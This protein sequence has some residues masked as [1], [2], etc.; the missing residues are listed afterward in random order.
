MSNPLRF[1]NAS[2]SLRSGRWNLKRKSSRR[3]A[4]GRRETP[5]RVFERVRAAST[6]W[7]TQ[8]EMQNQHGKARNPGHHVG[9][10]SSRP[11]TGSSPCSFARNHALG[12]LC[13]P[14]RFSA[15]SCAS[16]SNDRR[17]AKK[18]KE[19]GR[20]KPP[21]KPP[22]ESACA[23]SLSPVRASRRCRRLAKMLNRLMYTAVVAIT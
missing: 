7:R 15:S 17:E 5:G 12:F 23:H 14:R 16:G 19:K 3:S 6:P 2:F 8:E 22:L 10:V 20:P 13:G 4:E 9:Q 1:S 21:F 18:P 11:P